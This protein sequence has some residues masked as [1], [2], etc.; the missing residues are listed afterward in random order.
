MDEIDRDAWDQLLSLARQ[1]VRANEMEGAMIPAAQR[2]TRDMLLGRFPEV[3]ATRIE[4]AAAFAARAAS[5]LYCGRT[6][7]TS[8]DRLLVDR[9]VSALDLVA[10]QVF[11][12]VWSYAY[13][14]CFRRSAQILNARLAAR[15]RA[16]LY[17]QNSPKAAAKAAAYESWKRWRAN[18]GLYRSKSAFALAMLDTNQELHSQQTI[19]RWCRAWER[20]SE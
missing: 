9:S 11:T 2:R 10:Y 4:N 15:R 13:H 6:D 18:P 12:E 7:L 20:I 17:H 16:S 8:G 14:D 1:D 3:D 19:E 5:R